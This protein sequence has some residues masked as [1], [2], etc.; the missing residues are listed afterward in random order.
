MKRALV[1]AVLVALAAAG[2]AAAYT[3]GTVWV[4]PGHCTKVATSRVC[5]RTTPA[6][7]VAQTT[8]TQTITV[9]A[10]P[11]P[12]AVAFG[13]GTFRVGADIVAGTYRAPGGPS[14]YWERLRGFSGGFDD[15]VANG[16]G[17]IGPIVTIDPSD[18]GFR[19]HDCGGW[20]RIG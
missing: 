20:T 1:A 15:I 14:C 17:D 6:V 4:Q 16:F 9:T 2:T 18:A 10:P 8:V 12:P 13:P 5:A 19:S 3:F 11:P 7:T